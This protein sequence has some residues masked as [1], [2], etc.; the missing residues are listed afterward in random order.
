MLEANLLRQERERSPEAI[1]H[2]VELRLIFIRHG[3]KDRTDRTFGRLTENGKEQLRQFALEELKD[4]DRNLVIYG[5]DVARTVQSGLAAKEKAAAKVQVE[6][7]YLNGLS[8]NLNSQDP[9]RPSK[10]SDEFIKKALTMS[11]EENVQYLMSFGARRPDVGTLAPRELAAGIAQIISGYDKKIDKMKSQSRTDVLMVSHDFV[12]GAFLQE[13]M[14]IM[15]DTG[16]VPMNFAEAFYVTIKVDNE[17]KHK[18]VFSFRDQTVDLDMSEI[19][20]LANFKYEE[21]ED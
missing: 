17:G 1:G 14:E 8:L 7:D 6:P 2:N 16:K 9:N 10:M 19:E 21:K 13:A 20:K 3:E 11:S 12:L 5:T 15:L 4:P 18:V